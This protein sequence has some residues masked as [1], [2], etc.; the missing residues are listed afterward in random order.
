ML[1]I[2]KKKN[3][4]YL[5]L[6]TNQ[7]DTYAVIII[8]FIFFLI[9][10]TRS[11]W[12]LCIRPLSAFEQET[13]IPWGSWRGLEPGK[14]GSGLVWCVCVCVRIAKC[15]GWKHCHLTHRVRRVGFE[16]LSYSSSTPFLLLLFLSFLVHEPS[17][18]SA[19]FILTSR[20][21]LL[22]L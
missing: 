2:S 12:M 5:F 11:L 19:I 10:S 9:Y 21:I 7:E 22:Q 14:A 3:T 18:D 8:I 6:V 4:S 16:I 20:N 15:S 13:R 1:V 17:R